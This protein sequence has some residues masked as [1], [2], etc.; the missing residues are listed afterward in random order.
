MG[1]GRPKNRIPTKKPFDTLFFPAA[2][3]KIGEAWVDDR[4]REA[5]RSTSRAETRWEFRQTVR[6]SSAEKD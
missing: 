1:I 4:R 6:R 3:E 2:R 5:L